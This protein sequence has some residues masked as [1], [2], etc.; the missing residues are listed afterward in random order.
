MRA[1]HQTL[2]RRRL[3]ANWTLMLHFRSVLTAFA[4]ALFC[5]AALAQ[6]QAPPTANMVYEY[7]SG[8]VS[9]DRSTAQVVISHPIVLEGA[10]W[11]RLYFEDVQLSGDLLAGTGA[12][13]RMTALED[14]AIQEMDARHLVQWQNSSAYF[15][16]DTVLVEVLAQPGTGES[17]LVMRSVDYGF[18]S[19]VEESICGANDDRVLSSDPR[20]ARVLPIG[21]TGWL[22]DD[23]RQCFLTAGHCSSGTSTIQFNV[24][25]SDGNGSINHPGPQDQYA[26]DSASM[27]SNGGQGVGNDWAYFGT[28]PNTNTGL[29]AGQAQGQAFSLTSPPNPNGN[30]IRITGYGTDSS[31]SSHNQVQQTHAGPMVTGTSTTVQYATDTT[32][33]NSGSPVIWEQ[34][35]QAVGIH[36]HGGCSSSGGQ[37]SG[38]SSSHPGLQGALANP[39][40]ICAAGFNIPQPFPTLV[41]P[42]VPIDLQIE[43]VGAGSSVT[44]HWRLQ[45]GAFNAQPMTSQGG[46]SYSGQ[47]P[48]PSCGDQAEFYFSYQEGSCGLLTSPNDAPA[49]FYSAAVGTASVA[50]ADDFQADLGWNTTVQ[51][52][53]TG[54]WQR[55][56]PVNDPNWTYDPQ[57]DS[58]GSGSCYL[59]QNQVGNTDVDGGS[60]SLI[61]PV[62][63]ITG[64]GTFVSYDYYLYLTQEDGV[65][66]LLVE[67]RNGN[68]PW[69]QVALHT[70]SGGTSWRTHVVAQGDFSSAG[71]AISNDVQMRFTANDSD[72]QSINESGLDAFFVGKID[73]GDSVGT[74]YCASGSAGAVISATGS[75]SIAANDLVLQGT[76][77][78]PN[79][80]ALF[81][82]GDLQTLAPLGN[83]LLCVA[84][85]NGI[86]RLNPVQST[87]GGGSISHAVDNT[88]PPNA[89][90]LLTPG[91][92]WNF[93]LWFRDGPTSDLTDAITIIF[94]P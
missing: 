72:P 73:C 19:E 92:T 76:G 10:E 61:S 8:L 60:V 55:G 77:A 63:D 66:R 41:P 48:P 26:V 28:F 83:G 20:S 71:I 93:Q 35:G 15:N 39:I 62:I 12:I 70:T 23:C 37:N 27:Q 54:Q 5:G 29:T 4:G 52:A 65:D 89:L 53:S 43:I 80:S 31:P 34:T 51:G 82:Y 32:G 36:T 33:G 7:D 21:C 64:V 24:P 84:G 3:S 46:G 14:G 40:G 16:G 47:I 6:K 59:T 45:G 74:N 42:G 79:V 94:A 78:L 11:M 58:D 56:V 68:G 2:L 67:A 87:S 17:R 50:F 57:S 86:F 1:V 81:F 22:I 85:T 25:L 75:N 91:S 38:T 9:N 44:L 49:S 30:N 69:A 88:N 13:L 90:G 18:V